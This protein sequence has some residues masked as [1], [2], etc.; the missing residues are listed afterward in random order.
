M[1]TIHLLRSSVLAD[2]FD[3]S[4]G[5]CSLWIYMLYQARTTQNNKDA[6]IFLPWHNQNNLKTS[7]YYFLNLQFTCISAKKKWTENSPIWLV[8]C[9]D[10][11][12]W[13]TICAKYFISIGKLCFLKHWTSRFSMI[14]FVIKWKTVWYS[15][16]VLLFL[17]SFCFL[18]FRT[19]QCS[20]LDY[21]YSCK[22]L[23]LTS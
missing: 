5:K 17:F 1:D 15:D 19:N 16:Q 4:V 20:V 18:N 8:Q 6:K 11:L 2:V 3:L 7:Y 9:R 22:F 21:R 13:K 14:F 12:W 23:V 10:F